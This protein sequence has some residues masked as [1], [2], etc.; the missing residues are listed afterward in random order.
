MLM[1]IGYGLA[2]HAGSPRPWLI[3]MLSPRRRR[4]R[5]GHHSP[6]AEGAL[7]PTWHR[8]PP[9]QA[10]ATILLRNHREGIHHE[11]RH[12]HTASRLKAP[13]ERVYRAFIDGDAS[14]SGCRPT[15]SPAVAHLEARV[16][17]SFRM[18]F[19]NFATG[20]SHAFG[21]EYLALELAKRIRYTG[22]LL[23]TPICRGDEGHHH[24]D[25][26][27]VGTS[28][29]IEQAGILSSSLV[30][31]CYLGWQE[32]RCSSP[33][34]WSP[35]SRTNDPAPSRVAGPKS[36]EPAGW[37]ALSC[38]M[39]STSLQVQAAQIVPL[40]PDPPRPGAAGQG[41]GQMEV[42]VRNAVLVHAGVTVHPL[43]PAQ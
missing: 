30:A 34:W 32:S 5:A 35:R 28:L 10:A 16:G 22:S 39:P 37:Q 3:G 43:P 24:P 13:P 20:H 33:P 38:A 11:H 15:A 1:G 14:P 18:A 17:G 9:T 26:G 12:C 19:S 31:M 23:T 6:G 25:R 41:H 21:G 8:P 27:G 40:C 42:E 29:E 7:L 36:K 4:H 2:C